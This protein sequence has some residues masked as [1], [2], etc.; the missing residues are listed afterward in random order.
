MKQ[1]PLT[2]GRFALV[3]NNS[4]NYISKFK[5]YFGPDGYARRSQYIG[6][7]NGNPIVKTIRM[8]HLIVKKPDGFVIDHIDGDRLNNT[9]SNLRVATRSQN[10]MNRISLNGS[11][12]YKGVTWNKKS[13]KW[14]AQIWMN[15]KC[16]VLGQFLNEKEAAK[17][18]NQTAVKYQ[19]KFAR[20]NEV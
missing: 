9:R 6:L 10:N 18:Y 3:D 19:G 11:S 8:H 15:N 7:K 16:K 17:V 1:I 12:K 13:K 2:K 20:L 5:W 14:Q 4:F